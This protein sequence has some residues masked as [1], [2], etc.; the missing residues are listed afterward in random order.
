MSDWTRRRWLQV[1]A[2]ALLGA[3]S[4][5]A[6]GEEKEPAIGLGFSLYGMKALK[7]DDA[8]RSCAEIGYDGVEL[9]LMP[10]WP[11]EP[12]GLSAADRKDLGKRLADAGLVLMGLMENLME[13][14]EDAAHRANLDRLKAAAELGHVLSPKAPPVIETILGGRPAQWDQV[15]GKLAE[16]LKAWADTAAAAKTVVAVKPHVGNALHTPDAARWLLAQV[17]SPWLRLAFDY[18]HFGL[19]KLALADTVK[20]LVSDSVFVHVKD[21]KGDADKFE[22]LL[23]G[24]GTTDYVEYLKLLK[25][26]S[27]KGPVV[28]EV[29]GQISGRPG[30]DAV[31]AAKKCHTALAP[32]FEKAGV[33]RK[34]PKP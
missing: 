27:Y 1:T 2:G 24:E 16:R 20:A 13:P 14:A 25:T 23:P 19:R 4:L 22:F 7:T 26:A 6:G 8:L 28:V 10:G 32:A 21:Y 18:S 30:Y 34:R 17:N 9:A 5:R 33:R 29:S 11:T 3:T 31:A 12:K 15:K